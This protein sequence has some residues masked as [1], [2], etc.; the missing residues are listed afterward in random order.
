MQAAMATRA[1]SFEE[2]LNEKP[3]LA[4]LCEHVSISTKWYHMG[5]Q[6]KL[7]NRRL[8]EI[9]KLP[10]DVMDKMTKM[11]ELWLATNPQ[12]SRRQILDVLRRK[13]IEEITLA[14]QY[15]TKLREL[16]SNTGKSVS[17]IISD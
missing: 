13:A 8:K 14:H 9:D 16:Y 12:A 17:Q 11:Y 10:V 2:I 5:V 15:E 6:L 3:S 7:N 1:M 4:E